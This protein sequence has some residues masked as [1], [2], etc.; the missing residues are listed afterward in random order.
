MLTLPAPSAASLLHLRATAG[1]P[2]THLHATL[3]ALVTPATSA[4]ARPRPRLDE[5]AVTP[6]LQI[7]GAADLR[8][9]RLIHKAMEIRP[10]TC[11]MHSQLLHLVGPRRRSCIRAELLL[12]KM[13]S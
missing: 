10:T 13:W 6:T 8:L 12:W 4:A 7:P 3:A 2:A 5:S 1:T 9:P 11:L